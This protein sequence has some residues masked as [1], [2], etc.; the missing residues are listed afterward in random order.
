MEKTVDLSPA[1]WPADEYQRY[2][3]AQSVDRTTAGEAKGKNGAVTVAYSGIAARAGLEALKQGG[4]AVDAALTTAMAQIVVSASAPVSFFGILSMVYYDAKSGKTTT[5]GAEWNTVKG[6]TDPLSIPGGIAFGSDDS[7]RGSGEPSGRTALVG[8]FMK[9]VEAAHKKFGVL[10]FAQLFEPSIY[11]AE[12][13]VPINPLVNHA[14]KMREQDLLR[15]PE[16]KSI[17]TKPNGT[18]YKTGENFK[19]LALATT[20]RKLATE[21]ADYMYKG[22]WGKK[23]IAAIQAD[24][25]KMTM[26]DLESYE[27]QWSDPVVCEL[28]NG[29][30]LHMSQAPNFGAPNLVEALNLAEEANLAEDGPWWE[31]GPALK[32]A[33]DIA[34]QFGVSLLPDAMVGQMYPGMD[35]SFDA[36]LTKAHAKELWKRMEAGMKAGRF[37]PRLQHSDDVVAV[38]KDGNMCAITHSINCVNW[39]KTAIFIDGI[40]ISDAAGFQQAQVAKVQPG[41]RLPA[42][43]EQGI[44]FKDGQPVL[45]FASMGAG[46]HHRSFQCLTNVMKFGM[47]IPDA[48]NAPDFYMSKIDVDTFTSMIAVPVG[49]FAKDVLDATGYEWTEIPI[50]EARL[51]GEGKWVAISRDPHT[52][53][54]EAGSHNRNNSDALAY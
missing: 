26:E 28:A 38:D 45:A 54:L 17:F 44:L 43:T 46:L 22:S 1:R 4:N 24:G 29:Y 51:G 3:G 32:K 19:Q 48:I 9:G 50:E 10:P 37:R 41:D 7:L 21:G 11:L 34:N 47:T 25:G 52:G 5:M 49:R 20:L 35:F 16:T 53:E 6:E 42:P 2:L 13:G 8:G 15:L 14:I 36:R 39:G 31:S 33:V 40:S 12:Q 27:V 23:L 30:T 18:F